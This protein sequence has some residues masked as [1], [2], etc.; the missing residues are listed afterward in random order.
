MRDPK[1]SWTFCLLVT[2]CLLGFILSPG[3]GLNDCAAGTTDTRPVPYDPGDTDDVPSAAARLVGVTS[4]PV[5]GGCRYSF[6]VEVFATCWKP[7]YSLQI[8]QLAETVVAPASW[9]AGWVAE[10][11]P[12]TLRSAGSIVFSTTGEPLEPAE[13]LRGFALVSYSAEATLRW[14]PADEE[15]VLLGKI[16]RIELGCATATEGQTWGSIKTIY[17]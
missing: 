16:T 6:D 7:V 1:P 5:A 17:R 2:A 3:P 4:S 8:E 15:G 12:S 11:V 9:P 10:Q 13:V 14:Y